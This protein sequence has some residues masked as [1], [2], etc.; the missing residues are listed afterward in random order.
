MEAPLLRPDEPCSDN[1]SAIAG[2]RGRHH[3]ET[4][5]FR[6]R[7]QLQL[8]RPVLRRCLWRGLL[9]AGL[10]CGLLAAREWPSAE[11]DD[12]RLELRNGAL[13]SMLLLAPTVSDSSP[14][15]VEAAEPAAANGTSP[16]RSDIE[17]MWNRWKDFYFHFWSSEAERLCQKHTIT[18]HC[19]QQMRSV[20]SLIRWKIYLSM[21]LTLIFLYVVLKTVFYLGKLAKQAPPSY[22]R[23]AS[24]LR[25]KDDFYEEVD[26]TK[27]L[28]ETVQ[29][30]IDMTTD[31]KRMGRG[32]DGK[33]V[34][35]NRLR[36]KQVTRIENGRLWTAYH[37]SLRS[38]M[39]VSQHLEKMH[40]EEARQQARTN[41]DNSLKPLRYWQANDNRLKNFVRSLGLDAEKG[42]TIL[43]HGAPGPGARD[44]AT[45]AV[46]FDT[47]E[48]SPLHVIKR[49]GM[50]DRLGSVRGMLGS[51]T[52]FADMASKADQY[53]GKYSE[54][55]ETVGEEASM[56]ISRVALGCPYIT[57][58]SLE[59]LRRPPCI[60]GHF[61]P[62]LLWNS[63][64]LR[65]TPWREKGV[66][67]Q[68][69][70]HPRYDSVISEHTIDGNYKLYKEYVVYGKQAYP[71]F[72]VT[73]VRERA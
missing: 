27:E 30:L 71:E 46:R 24:Y 23:N 54:D 72:C 11:V 7:R 26:V 56:F 31:P 19:C 58:M 68:T 5:L 21:A 53:A 61:D 50:D 32:M 10:V 34:R 63:D 29:K 44:L 57:N 25:H 36:V 43:F 9:G 18:E 67:F 51:G 3:A 16:L 4:C 66:N 2:C 69:C 45:K 59:L 12:A 48:T 17:D 22:W 41:C 35:H 70:E 33:W 62:S 60:H 8:S 39:S 14:W 64:E 37:H 73:Y 65:G 15:W 52:Y 49:A 28:K 47:L 40:T 6:L 55:D 13:P 42:E 1:S 38:M 20:A